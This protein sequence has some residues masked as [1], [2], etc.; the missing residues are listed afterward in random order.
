MQWLRHE[1][2]KAETDRNHEVIDTTGDQ[3]RLIVVKLYYSIL[4]VP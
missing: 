1:V 3:T 4:C 2:T